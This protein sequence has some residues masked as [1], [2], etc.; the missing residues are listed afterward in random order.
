M[1]DEKILKD[2]VLD[3]EHLAKLQKSIREIEEG[4]VVSFSDE[5]WE[6]FIN[7]EDI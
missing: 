1:K 3:D 5:E 6:K 7:A 4:K 2:E